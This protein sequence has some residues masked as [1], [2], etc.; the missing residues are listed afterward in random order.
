[1]INIENKTINALFYIPSKKR[2]LKEFCEKYYLDSDTTGCRM[3]K[4]FSRTD[5]LSFLSDKTVYMFYSSNIHSAEKLYDDICDSFT[6]FNEVILYLINDDNH[7]I[8]RRYDK[9]YKLEYEKDDLSYAHYLSDNWDK[10]NDYAFEYFEKYAIGDASHWYHK[11]VKKIKANKLLPVYKFFNDSIPFVDDA[12]S[13]KCIPDRCTNLLNKAKTENE[14]LRMKLRLASICQAHSFVFKFKATINN[15]EVNSLKAAIYKEK[16]EKWLYAAENH[17]QSLNTY[18]SDYYQKLG[19]Q[20]TSARQP[21]IAESKHR[22]LIQKKLDELASDSLYESMSKEDIYRDIRR[23]KVQYFTIPKNGN[24]KTNL[25]VK[26]L[27]TH[28]KEIINN[29]G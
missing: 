22:A 13:K 25:T 11:N 28:I 12:N 29:L 26:T 19:K 7:P 24:P 14:Y 15:Q 27:K 16:T 20:K 10:V 4:L 18:L 3:F 21:K 8:R 9:F 1:M 2:G 23:N 5:D 6:N 17:R